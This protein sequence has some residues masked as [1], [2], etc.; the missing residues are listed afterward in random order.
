MT[1]WPAIHASVVEQFR[2]GWDRPDPH[3][4]D[5]FMDPSMRFVQPM[6]RDVVGPEQ[7][8]K[9]AGRLLHVLPDLRAD[10]VH[11]AGCRDARKI[12]EAHVGYFVE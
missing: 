11:W 5:S 4:W 6:L 10:V 9:E 7:W 1:D 12:G 3:S 2:A 8:W